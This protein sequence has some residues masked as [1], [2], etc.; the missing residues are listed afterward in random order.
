MLRRRIAVCATLMAIA[1]TALQAVAQQVEGPIL[2]PKSPPPAALLVSCDLA[3]NWELDGE[4][5]GHIDAGGSAKAKIE[6]GQH[7]LVVVTNDGLDKVE[8][9]IEIKT[10][11]QTM[12][13]VALQPIRNDRIQAQ[14]DADPV[15]L[16]EHAAERAKVGQ[17]LYD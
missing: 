15:Y 17:S 14:Q 10:A 5:K 7:M 1:V 9:D 3:C 12:F 13:R 16:R 4:T 11:G 6:L 2:R 8:K